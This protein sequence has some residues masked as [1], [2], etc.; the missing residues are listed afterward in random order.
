[1]RKITILAALLICC[2]GSSNAQFFKTL[3]DKI[4]KAAEKAVERKAE[5]KTTEETE[6]A[7]DSIFDKEERSETST[8]IASL[9]KVE[10]AASYDFHH[11]VVMQIENEKEVM[12]IDYF[13]SNSGNY[14]AVQLKDKKIKEGYFTVFDVEREAMF[15][16]M[17][18]EGQK[19]KMGVNFKTE[20]TTDEST[21]K[22][23]ATGNTKKILAYNCQEYKMTGK[24]LISTIWV[25]KEVDIRFP[26]DF[27]SIK[28]NKSTKQ[29]WMK[30]IDG[31][32]MEMEM[33]DYSKK[34]PQTIIMNCISIEA[35]SFKINS[36]DYQSMGL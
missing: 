31:W 33:T 7:F 18:N 27:Y 4:G 9:S 35:S 2:S 28:Q 6:A 23:Q 19:V 8:G 11:K 32:A 12:D 3:G 30:D 34:K 29:A 16:Y 36:N 17:N 26:S 15:T 20:E 13:L 14:L 22:I 1:M 10:P 5:Q 25:T 24:D 21:F